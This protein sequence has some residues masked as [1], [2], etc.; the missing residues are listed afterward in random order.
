MVHRALCANY[1]EPPLPGVSNLESRARARCQ[2][3]PLHDPQ[4]SAQHMQ[5]WPCSH[6]V[7]LIKN[8]RLCAAPGLDCLNPGLFRAHITVSS[9][10]CQPVH[11]YQLHRH[12]LAWLPRMCFVP[13]KKKKKKGNTFSP[14]NCKPIHLL[15]I[16]SKMCASFLPGILGQEQTGCSNADHCGTLGHLVAKSVRNHL[17]HFLGLFL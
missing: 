13:L 16:L 17:K 15:N 14:L 3:P 9:D 5:Q 2:S 7:E 12:Y 1:K 10:F 6:C 4:H 11:L 8:P